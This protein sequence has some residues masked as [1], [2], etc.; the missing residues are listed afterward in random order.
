M[1]L[2]NEINLNIIRLKVLEDETS[3]YVHKIKRHVGFILAIVI[4]IIISSLLLLA[5]IY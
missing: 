4:L 5:I 2:L 1:D 3:V